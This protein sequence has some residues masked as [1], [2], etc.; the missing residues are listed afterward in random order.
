M[1][2]LFQARYIHSLLLYQIRFPGANDN[3]MWFAMGN[4]KVKLGKRE[5]Y[6]CTGLKFGV[7]PDFFL[8]DYIPVTMRYFG[9][10][11]YLLLDQ[12]LSRFLRGEF[13]QK[14]DGLKTTLVL[15][16]NNILFGQDYQRQ[17]TYWPM[18]LVKDTHAFN[19]FPW[20]HF[21]FK[22]TL[23]YI[24]IGFKVAEPMGR[25]MR[26]NLY[27]FIWGVQFWAM[28]AIKSMRK[29]LGNRFASH[30]HPRFKK[31]K[32]IKWG[33]N[34]SESWLNKEAEG[35]GSTST[36]IPQALLDQLRIIVCEEVQDGMQYEFGKLWDTL[37]QLFSSMRASCSSVEND[38][39]PDNIDGDPAYHF[40]SEMFVDLI[41]T[42]STTKDSLSTIWKKIQS[43]FHK[44]LWKTFYPK[45]FEFPIEL[46]TYAIR[47]KHD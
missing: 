9:T 8:K 26:Y 31:W 44:A 40:Q 21:V 32:F 37:L 1:W 42:T 7:L 38:A 19:S 34:M 5:F 33:S 28:E 30:G 23:H 14:G 39:V 29:K 25:T 46:I 47:E 41:I 18:S 3:E 20:G 4:T 10:D 43:D 24:R 11:R 15:F 35:K 2:G 27:G 6:L 17:V 12:L 45:E 36:V 16:T 22:M 13:D